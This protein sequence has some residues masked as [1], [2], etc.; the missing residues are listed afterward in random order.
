MQWYFIT[1][2]QE[3]SPDCLQER[4]EIICIE[5]VV[6]NQKAHYVLQLEG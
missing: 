6:L 4:F 1:F 2:T 3:C 5:V